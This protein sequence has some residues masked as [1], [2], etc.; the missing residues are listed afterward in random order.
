MPGRFITLPPR[1]GPARVP[2]NRRRGA[3]PTHQ[4]LHGTSHPRGTGRPS[5]TSGL[6]GKERHMKR[7]GVGEDIVL[8][9]ILLASLAVPF[10][11]VH[12]RG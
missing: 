12:G 7:G 11:L 9:L 10:P 1:G 4:V 3:D 2:P 5:V 8:P 6:N